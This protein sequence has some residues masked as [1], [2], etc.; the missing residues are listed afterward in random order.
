MKNDKYINM[1][2]YIKY[3]GGAGGSYKFFKKNVV[4][5]EITDLNISLPSSF[6]G[7]Y[8]MAL[9]IYFCGLLKTFLQQYFRVALTIIFKF[10]IT[11]EV[12]IHNNI[13]IIILK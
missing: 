9:I 6:F 1:G 12:N 10:Q 2:A 7:K 5:Q 11:K 4:A 3:V 13:Q 8:F